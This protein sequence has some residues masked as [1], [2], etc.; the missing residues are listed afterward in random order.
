MRLDER[1]HRSLVVWAT[2]C[3]DHALPCFE[4]K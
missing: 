1:D 2:D 3:A 4:E